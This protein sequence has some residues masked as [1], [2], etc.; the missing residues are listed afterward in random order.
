[1][2]KHG[3][4]RALVGLALALMAGPAAAAGC[5]LALALGMD[6]S[7]SVDARDY[8]IERQGLI[9]ALEAPQ[10]RRAFLE[11][12]DRVMFAVYEWSG[13]GDQ[14]VIVPWILVR[15]A[16]DL[17]RLVAVVAGHER[18]EKRLP[19][20]LG[21]A[22]SFGRALLDQAPGCAART[23]DIAGD[24]QNNVGLAPEQIYERLDFS[25]ITVNGLPIGDHERDISAY[26]QA[27]VIHG[28]GA[29]IQPA[30]VQKDF[31]QAI[32]RKLE[33]ERAGRR[34]GARPT[35]APG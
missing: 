25:G 32:R 14:R 21:E 26:Y 6:V 10:I 8:E 2:G 3:K 27:Q 20:A 13:Q 9:A 19:T 24:G 22:L 7:R 17:D 23:L 34:L 1:M 18:A 31:P 29:F 16:D 11:G 30:P 4:Y 15:G 12:P 33:R 35:A 28:P 5:R